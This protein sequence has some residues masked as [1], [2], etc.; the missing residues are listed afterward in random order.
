M[1]YI[2]EQTKTM[3]E[4][5]EELQIPAKTLHQWKAQYRTFENEPLANAAKV[6]E[7]KQLL[8]EKEHDLKE[9][10][11]ELADTKEEMAFLKKAMH[12]FSKP[13]N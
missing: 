6:R 8:K 11:R 7:L 2:Q 5:A 4:I 3:P 10:D 13:R 9:K 1:K 12:I